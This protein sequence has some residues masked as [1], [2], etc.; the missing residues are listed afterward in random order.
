MP[1]HTGM[2]IYVDKEMVQVAMENVGLIISANLS[3]VVMLPTTACTAVAPA[4][5]A[6]PKLGG[7]EHVKMCRPSC[8][9]S[10][11]LLICQETS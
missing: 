9:A 5:A 6:Y 3:F 11:N 4:V 7:T 1:L 8:L 2:E 10:F